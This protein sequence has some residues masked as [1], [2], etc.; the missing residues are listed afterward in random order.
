MHFI[1]K[2][3]ILALGCHTALLFIHKNIQID[4]QRYQLAQEYYLYCFLIGQY[5][6]PQREGRLGS[7]QT[8]K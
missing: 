7:L 3:S 1:F 2:H 4:F 8:I 5:I 6:A